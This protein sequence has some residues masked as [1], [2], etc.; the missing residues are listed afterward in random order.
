MKLHTPLL[1]S[2]SALALASGPSDAENIAKCHKRNPDILKAIHDFCNKPAG[3]TIMVP[4]PYADAGTTVGKAH[5]SVTGDCKPKQWLPR[6]WCLL[7]FHEIC[8]LD[9]GFSGKGYG[10]MLQGRDNCQRFNIEKVK[11]G[12]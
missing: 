11:K 5:V 7:Q 12:K 4:S 2:L 9:M 6:K 8:G 1:L 10:A 3:D